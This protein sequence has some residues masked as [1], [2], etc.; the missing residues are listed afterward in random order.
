MA[1]K[2][3]FL[4]IIVAAII[5]IVSSG[6]AR[7]SSTTYYFTGLCSDCSGTVE[8]QLVLGGYVPG[9]S[10]STSVFESFTYDGSNLQPAFTITTDLIRL[11]G[12]LGPSFPG[13]FY[14]DLVG[15]DTDSEFMEF[16]SGTSGA[17]SVAPFSIPVDNGSRSV[18][19]TTQQTLSAPE[20]L[21]AT[22]LGTGLLGLGLVRR[23]RAVKPHAS[24]M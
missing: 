24:G 17:W 9:A 19:G 5:S 22:L 7:A 4:G 6:A 20:P 23:R 16:T 21:S 12:S 10:L 2:T 14:V 3:Y 18:W 8:A 1:S 13:Q 11:L 15:D